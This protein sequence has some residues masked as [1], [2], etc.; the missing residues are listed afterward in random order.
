MQYA[1]MKE[2]F[3]SLRKR[4]RKAKNERLNSD[5]L[6]TLDETYK[7]DDPLL[8]AEDRVAAQQQSI[9]NN[10]AEMAHLGKEAEMVA[11]DTLGELY[12]NNAT[13]QGTSARVH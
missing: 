9:H 5:K 4:F 6:F 12:R 1:K 8:R 3:D 7:I 2:D 10:M 11:T 13:L